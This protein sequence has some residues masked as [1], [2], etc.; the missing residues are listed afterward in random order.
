M[1]TRE[2]KAILSDESVDGVKRAIDDTNDIG[3]KILEIKI[4]KK[5]NGGFTISELIITVEF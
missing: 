1:A 4:V 2:F 3:G 5:Q